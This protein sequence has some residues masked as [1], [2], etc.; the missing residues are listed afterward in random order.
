MSATIGINDLKFTIFASG[1]DYTLADSGDGDVQ[2]FSHPFVPLNSVNYAGQYYFL[3][4][5]ENGDPLD[6]V[7]DDIAHCTFTPALG[8]TFDT[9]GET[10][11]EVHYHREYIYDEETLVVDKTVSQVIQVVNHGSVV[12]Q[13]NNLD[14][15]SDGYGFIRPLT[16]NGV[17]VKDYTIE[18]RNAVTKVSSFPWRATGLGS[19]TI[20]HFFTSTNLTDISEWKYADVSKCTKL[21][22]LFA[23]CRS[24]SDISAIADWDVSN[25]TY[26]YEFLSYS[27]I[28]SLKAL[29]KWNVSKCTSLENAFMNFIGSKLDGLEHWDVSNVT[30]MK[31]VFD[32]NENLTDASAIANWDVSKVQRIDNGF[33]ASKLTN[34][35]AFALWNVASLKNMQAIFKLCEHLTD[36][37]G[38]SNWQADIINISEAFA[39]C[40]ALRDLSGVHGLN[41]ASVT[42]FHE[43]FSFCEYVTTLDGLDEWDVSNGTNFYRMFKGCP[44]IS[45]ISAIANWDMSN[46]QN[47]Y[48]MFMGCAWTT[49]VDDLVDWR[50]TSI[51]NIEGMFKNNNGCYSSLLGKRLTY[52][53]YYYY[54]YDGN[55]MTHVGVE[56]DDHPLTYPTYDADKASGWIASGTGYNAFDNRWVNV[57]AWN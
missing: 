46:A 17:E 33:T 30:N 27:N 3:V 47:M 2:I 56:D 16:V 51:Q 31:M 5:D 21:V 48:E 53:A 37:S 38:L 23:G 44:W 40:Y 28:S 12:D 32:H 1:H 41:V 20:Y 10:T 18:Q 11:V 55:Q 7:K 29:E 15:Y 35:N 34:T 25:V 13:T 26:I 4:P 9:E 45:D 24:L 6:C 42:D 49:D 19:G 52:D 36:L 39:N 43:V 8:S 57:P 54:D 22:C 50:L 14:V